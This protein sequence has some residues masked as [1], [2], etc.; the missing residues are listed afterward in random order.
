[1]CIHLLEIVPSEMQWYVCHTD[2]GTRVKS[3]ANALD[4]SLDRLFS[5][6][7][8]R[9]IYMYIYILIESDSN[10]IDRTKE[11]RIKRFDVDV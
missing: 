2:R 3:H 4:A 9:Y 10:R 8:S 6:V 1:M 11:Y 7:R 5:C